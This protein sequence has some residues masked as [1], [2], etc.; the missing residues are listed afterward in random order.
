MKAF[1]TYEEAMRNYPEQNTLA[2]MVTDYFIAGKSVKEVSLYCGISE[3][4]VEDYIRT[5]LLEG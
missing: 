2:R 4:D 3:T 1:N 5:T